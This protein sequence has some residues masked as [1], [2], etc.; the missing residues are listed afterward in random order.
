M[1]KNKPRSAEATPARDDRLTTQ[2]KPI[3]PSDLIWGV[4]AIAT[5]INRSARQV[6]FLITKGL[7]PIKRLGDRTIVARTSELDRYFS[8][9]TKPPPRGEPKKIKPPRVP[10]RRLRPRTT[11]R[12]RERAEA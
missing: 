12:E 7:I 2:P 1:S 11:T 5:Y 10:K 6:Y 8:D 3:V 9:A 4:D